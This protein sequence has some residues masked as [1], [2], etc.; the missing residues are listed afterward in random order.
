MQ[1]DSPLLSESYIHPNFV[2][3][4]KTMEQ[5]VNFNNELSGRIALVTGGTKGAGRAIAECG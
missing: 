4:S 2:Q 1:F 3:K 5:I